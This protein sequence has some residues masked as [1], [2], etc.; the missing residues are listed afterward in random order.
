MGKSDEIPSAEKS[1]EVPSDKSEGL[2]YLDKKISP[3]RESSSTIAKEFLQNES[4]DF[5]AE[6]CSDSGNHDLAES[7]KKEEFVEPTL[8]ESVNVSLLI[9]SRRPSNGDFDDSTAE[10]F[11][12]L[13]GYLFGN[14]SLGNIC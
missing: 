2:E 5:E 1:D 11:V 6:I 9:N 14:E 3:S 8:N 13:E 4:C 7:N 10:N 12:H